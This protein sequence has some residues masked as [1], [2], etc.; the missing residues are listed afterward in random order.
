M[1]KGICRLF[2]L[3]FGQQ[4]FP[5]QFP[6]AG[7]AALQFDRLPQCVYGLRHRARLRIGEAQFL[8]GKGIIRRAGDDGLQAFQGSVSLSPR[9]RCAAA[10]T[11]WQLISPG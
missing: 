4:Q 5:Q 6:A 9:A 1:V 10:T 3:L 11:N 8:L 7:Q 2:F